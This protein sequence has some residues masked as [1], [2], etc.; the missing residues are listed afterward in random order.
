MFAIYIFCLNLSLFVHNC[1][2]LQTTNFSLFFV[3]AAGVLFDCAQ[4]KSFFCRIRSVYL[5]Y[6]HFIKGP[7]YT[8]PPI[9]L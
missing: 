3:Y 8:R 7:S 5:V 2:L 9:N 6:L 1:E 4:V